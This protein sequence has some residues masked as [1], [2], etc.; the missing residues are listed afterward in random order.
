MSVLRAPPV[1]ESITSTTIT[2]RIELGCVGSRGREESAALRRGEHDDVDEGMRLLEL[3]CA[4]DA[5]HFR[6]IDV[7]QYDRGR[8]EI[9]SLQRFFGGRKRSDAFEV[10]DSF[11]EDA[12]GFSNAFVVLYDGHVD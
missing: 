8:G 5:A 12:Q 9:E 10:F 4:F 2:H 7:H 3:A 11:H 1:A 6:E